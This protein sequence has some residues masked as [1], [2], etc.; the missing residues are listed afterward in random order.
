MCALNIKAKIVSVV[1]FKGSV[2]KE[3]GGKPHLIEGKTRKVRTVPKH[4]RIDII[5]RINCV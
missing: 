3:E 2:E 5:K 4:P 1:F